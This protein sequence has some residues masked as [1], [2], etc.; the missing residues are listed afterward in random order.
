[1]PEQKCLK[2]LSTLQG[3]PSAGQPGGRVLGPALLPTRRGHPAQ[4]ARGP[5][6]SGRSG[7]G[8]RCPCVSVNIA[9]A[10][11]APQTRQIP[12]QPP[13]RAAP[14]SS[15]PGAR[16]AARRACCQH[17]VRVRVAGRL[18]RGGHLCK[19]EVSGRAPS[20]APCRYTR[21]TKLSLLTGFPSQPRLAWEHTGG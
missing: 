2:V 18:G 17:P 3:F 10:P 7:Q 11:Q 6:R 12:Q 14:S 5:A 9:S 13:G 19:S 15:P 21:V 4:P 1:M 8:E 16:R 20:S